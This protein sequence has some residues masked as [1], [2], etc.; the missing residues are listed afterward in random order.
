VA[1]LILFP[2]TSAH[3]AMRWCPFCAR[4]VGCDATGRLYNHYLRGCDEICPGTGMCW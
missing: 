2:A 3:P 1:G 4:V